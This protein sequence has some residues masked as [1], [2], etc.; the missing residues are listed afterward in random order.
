VLAGLSSG[1]FV[2]AYLFSPRQQKHPYLLLTACFVGASVLTDYA[3]PQFSARKPPTALPTVQKPKNKKDK[4]RQMDASYEVLS[5]DSNS[6][7]TQSDQEIEEDFNGE[8]VR[9]QMEGFVN[10]QMIRTGIAG[11]GFVMGIIGL[12]GDGSANVVIVDY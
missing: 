10:G 5:H 9:S 11:L 2:L 8:Q 3:F 4:S 6:E 1:S 12:W 7:E